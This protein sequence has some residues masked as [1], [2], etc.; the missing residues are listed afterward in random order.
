[1]T[2]RSQI[3]TATA[4]QGLLLRSGNEGDICSVCNTSAVDIRLY[5]PSSSGA[6]NGGEAGFPLTIPPRGSAIVVCIDAATYH[7]VK[8]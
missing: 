4:S 7:A 8:S 3:P 2:R 5:P 6:F 1:M